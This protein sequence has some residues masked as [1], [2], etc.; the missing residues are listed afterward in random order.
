MSKD[1][2][3]DVHFSQQF[4]GGDDILG[5]VESDAIAHDD[6][7]VRGSRRNELLHRGALEQRDPALVFVG[8]DDSID[9]VVFMVERKFRVFLAVFVHSRDLLGQW[10][11]FIDRAS[12]TVSVGLYGFY[13][14][15]FALV[16][17]AIHR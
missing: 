12:D 9:E 15:V 16:H 13:A 10:R 17:F 6:M 1:R 7:G 8:R 2:Q 4:A 3:G 11:A 5:F 14:F